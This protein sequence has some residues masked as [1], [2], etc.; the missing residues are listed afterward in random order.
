V[1]DFDAALRDPARPTRLLPAFDS[2]D[3]CH[4]NDAGY[5]AMARVIDP[6]LFQD[7]SR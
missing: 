2:G 3:H 5:A 7:D 4:P 6:R 1:I